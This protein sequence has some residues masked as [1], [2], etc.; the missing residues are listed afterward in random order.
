M[1]MMKLECQRVIKMIDPGDLLKQ[2]GRFRDTR[3]L[4]NDYLLKLLLFE[5]YRVFDYK[6]IFKGDTSLKYFYNLNRFSEDLDF[7]YTGENN[8]VERGKINRKFETAM[9]SVGKQYIINRNEHRGRR[10]NDTVVGMNFELRVQGP[11]YESSRQMQNINIDISL[12]RDVLRESENKYMLPPY[13]DIP[14]FLVPVLNLE[15]I[16][17][18]KVASIME[19]DKIRDIYDLY[20]LLFLKKVKY[21]ESL[22][23]EKMSRRNEKFERNKLMEKIQ[24]ASS[25]M[26]WNSELSYLV[27]PLPDNLTVVK[28]LEN[29]LE[30]K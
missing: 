13:Q 26:K 10:E 4:E 23:I 20:F 22:V 27:N 30:L 5:I 11:L 18:E 17:A 3:Q 24:I 25:P 7:S 14:L 2:S 9:E 12:R 8:S 1:R 15:E 29:I 21:E 28:T 6:L 19:R 16:V